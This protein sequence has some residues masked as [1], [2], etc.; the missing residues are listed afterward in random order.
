MLQ[1]QRAA[2]FIV[3]TKVP[4]LKVLG[5]TLRN[6]E[7][8]SWSATLSATHQVN[9]TVEGSRLSS[10]NV[11]LR[12]V[13]AKLYGLLHP[14]RGIEIFVPKNY[15]GWCKKNLIKR[16]WPSKPFLLILFLLPMP[17]LYSAD[18]A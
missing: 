17:F 4:E 10:D 15:L 7:R 13:R 3:P 16:P 2:L 1:T 5:F 14:P 6:T 8:D 12:K 9:T 11:M 18:R